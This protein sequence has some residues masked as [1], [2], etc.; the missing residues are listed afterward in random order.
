ME[1]H[2]AL[3]LNAAIEILKSGSFLDIQKAGHHFQRNEFYRPFSCITG[4]TKS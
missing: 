4:T 1:N 3:T 2:S